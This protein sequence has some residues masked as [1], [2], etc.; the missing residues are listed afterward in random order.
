ML[1]HDHC[2]YFITRARS[3]CKLYGFIHTA[4]GSRSRVPREVV[5]DSEAHREEHR[6]DRDREHRPAPLGP[7]PDGIRSVFTDNRSVGCVGHSP[8]GQVI[9]TAD[10]PTGRRRHAAVEE[11]AS[12][13][14]EACAGRRVRHVAQRSEADD[15]E[16]DEGNHS[17]LARAVTETAPKETRGLSS[18]ESSECNV[19]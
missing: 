17:F 15:R 16:R 14:H 5:G 6:D 11:G 7:Q 8:V 12:W 10:R 2:Y 1:V 19:Q 9:E 3:T 18:N 13:S 4:T